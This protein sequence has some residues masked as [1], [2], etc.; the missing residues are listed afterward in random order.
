[1]KPSWLDSAGANIFRRVLY[2]HEST[3]TWECN[4]AI[5]HESDSPK[6]RL[7]LPLKRGRIMIKFSNK[8]KPL[9][10]W[11][12]PDLK[13]YSRLVDDYFKREVS[14]RSDILFT[15]TGIATML[16]RYFSG[17]FLYGRP[18]L[19]FD[20]SLLW[21]GQ[22][23]TL[24]YEIDGASEKPRTA[25]S[26][27][28]MGWHDCVLEIDTSVWSAMQEVDIRPDTM[29]T[30]LRAYSERSKNAWKPISETRSSKFVELRTESIIQ[31]HV[32]QPGKTRP[33]FK[34]WMKTSAGRDVDT[35]DEPAPK[36]VVSEPEQ[37]PEGILSGRRKGARCL[38][39][40][41]AW[42]MRR[43]ASAEHTSW[44][45]ISISDQLALH[46]VV[47][48]HHFWHESA[49]RASAVPSR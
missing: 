44:G 8:A 28:W 11:S 25:P 20:V 21:H 27:S 48:I 47:L 46:L 26:W 38:M 23:E 37:M 42:D 39:K 35:P 16:T 31:W 36:E 12:V 40:L 43:P 34:D 9:Q 30:R 29:N 1:M 2:F 15:F 49:Q 41:E 17:G 19:F 18:E 3:L 7:L 24:P 22:G 13:E 4:S 45:Q 14:F 33:M 10:Q 6:L 5:F 32:A